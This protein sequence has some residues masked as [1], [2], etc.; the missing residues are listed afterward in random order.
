MKGSDPPLHG[1]TT[2]GQLDHPLL[3]PKTHEQQRTRIPARTMFAQTAAK[4]RPVAQVAADRPEY[5]GFPAGIMFAQTK[6]KRRRLAQ[7]AAECKEILT[8]KFGWDDSD[9]DLASDV[10]HPNAPIGP[11]PD[12]ECAPFNPYSQPQPFR[13]GRSM[14]VDPEGDLLRFGGA[15]PSMEVHDDPSHTD[16]LIM[17][18]TDPGEEVDDEAAVFYLEQQELKLDCDI[19]YICVGPEKGRSRV[20]VNRLKEMVTV[21]CPDERIHTIEEWLCPSFPAFEVRNYANVRILQIGPIANKWLP[22]VKAYT[23]YLKGE[24]VTY[25]YYLQGALGST[26]NSK[27]GQSEKTAMLLRDRARAEMVVIGAPY[28]KFTYEIAM[29]YPEK[30]KNEILR[31]G[32]KNT[33]G[34]ADPQS[35]PLRYT[36]HLVG[37]GGANY[38]TA[39]SIYDG[40]KG[41]GAFESLEIP[42]EYMDTL[43]KS[44]A[45]YFTDDI[46]AMLESNVV[47]TRIRVANGQTII[48]QVE[49]LKRMLYAFFDLFQLPMETVLLSTD[50]R[51]S[52]TSL[53][54]P[55]VPLVPSVPLGPIKKAFNVFKEALQKK[56]RVEL[57][58][59]YDVKAA[60]AVVVGVPPSKTAL[61]E[62]DMEVTPSAQ[63]LE[64]H[65]L[66]SDI[67]LGLF[68]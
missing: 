43:K 19:H 11:L 5:T 26:T 66:V 20:R 68:R 41:Y 1:Y 59:M 34:R 40:I 17:V 62:M 36:A 51:L 52:E 35:A 45:T 12:L 58:P 47:A 50:D 8:S 57:T 16:T 22:S 10:F 3:N 37:P 61:D 7:V 9:D 23:D 38:E 32:F 21:R 31:I 54:V 2:K 46:L 27:D 42:S 48:Q 15:G 4:R 30:L 29:S 28:E 25:D 18:I 65:N 56:Q 14:E 6:A 39:K 67:K 33:V 49:G 53:V 60:Q 55:L 13:I 63:M 24:G 44:V 64:L